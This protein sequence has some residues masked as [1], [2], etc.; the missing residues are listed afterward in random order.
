MNAAVN[1]LKNLA[2]AQGSLQ[3]HDLSLTAKP[4]AGCEVESGPSEESDQV[5]SSGKSKVFEPNNGLDNS[6]RI[7]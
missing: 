1:L 4:L 3:N 6:L 2:N 7:Y 5:C